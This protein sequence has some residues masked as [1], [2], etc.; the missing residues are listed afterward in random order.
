MLSLVLS[1]PCAKLLVG[2]PNQQ[3]YAFRGAIDALST[4]PSTHTFSLTQVPYSSQHL[5][6]LSPAFLPAIGLAVL[7]G[8]TTQFTAFIYSSLRSFSAV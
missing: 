8:L 7:C 3:I 6:Q 2:D 1:Q 5:L 4:V